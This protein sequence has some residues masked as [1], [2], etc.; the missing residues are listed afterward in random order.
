MISENKL[1]H[2]LGVARACEK[3]AKRLG[4]T[5]EE[6]DA[7][8]VM[9]FLHD[10]GYERI[11]SENITEHPQKGYDLIMT[12]T[13]Y[14]PQ[15]SSAIQR[16]GRCKKDD[17]NTFDYILNYADLTTDHKGQPVSMEERLDLIKER[18]GENSIHYKHAKD[19]AEIL[20]ATSIKA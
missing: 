20:K 19:Q 13:S 10:I 1:K 2:I 7:C 15:I 16:H 6:Q 4:L 12:A 3:E 18:H 8:F 14:L 9:G 11:T 5:K 17:M